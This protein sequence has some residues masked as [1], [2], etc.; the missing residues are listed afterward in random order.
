MKEAP[1]NGPNMIQFVRADH[2]FFYS[3]LA[4]AA[5]WAENQKSTQLFSFSKLK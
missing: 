3:T 5:K 1:A 4:V 2:K